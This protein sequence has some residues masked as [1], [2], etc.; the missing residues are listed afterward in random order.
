MNMES[1]ISLGLRG[2]KMLFMQIFMQPENRW[3]WGEV[4]QA[5]GTARAKGRRLRRELG[6]LR[7]PNGM[8]LLDFLPGVCICMHIFCA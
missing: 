2:L 3:R 8:F 5:E 4:L 1:C 6:L 7:E